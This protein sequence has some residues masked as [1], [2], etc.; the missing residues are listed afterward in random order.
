MICTGLLIL[1]IGRH[2]FPIAFKARVLVLVTKYLHEI[3]EIRL[4]A[5]T[6]TILP[7]AAHRIQG[8]LVPIINHMAAGYQILAEVEGLI[9]EVRE[10]LA[11]E[12]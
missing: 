4:G 6:Q 11:D 1:L 7:K 2:Q 8:I 3:F 9:A 5:I 12:E 10:T